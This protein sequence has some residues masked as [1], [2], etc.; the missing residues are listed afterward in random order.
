MRLSFEMKVFDVSVFTV[1][2]MF[3]GILE[4]QYEETKRHIKFI[5]KNFS[6]NYDYC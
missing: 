2:S 1:E 5:I 6:L 3:V 4:F